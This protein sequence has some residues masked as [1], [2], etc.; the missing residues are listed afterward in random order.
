LK[1]TII[2]VITSNVFAAGI[3]FLLNILLARILSIEEFGRINLI[4]TLIIMLFSIFEFNFSNTT[5]IFYNKLKKR[6]YNDE[7][8]LLYYTNYLFLKYISYTSVLAIIIIFIIKY[9]YS[10][11]TLEISVISLNFIMF[12]LYRYIINLYQAVGEWRKFNFYN[13]LHN[14]IKSISIV[15]SILIFSIYFSFYSNYISTLIGSLIFPII[16]FIFIISKSKNLLKVKNLTSNRNKYLTIFKK[17][18]IPLGIS[19]IFIV[20]TMRADVLIIEKFLGSEALGIFAAAN[21]FALVFPLITSALRNV[22]LKESASKDKLFLKNILL[23]QRKFFPFIILIFIISISISEYLFDFIYGEK[24]KDSI[25]LFNLLLIAYIGGTFFTPLESYFYS[26]YPK[27]I[28]YL[29][30]YQMFI[31]LIFEYLLIQY[32]ELIG[33]AIAIILSRAFGW[34][35]IILKAKKELKGI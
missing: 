8:K 23:N 6:F 34:I 7:N 28:L 16:F 29:K 27:D 35:Y 11:S 22:Y 30:L 14:F 1:K 17:I 3:G 33:I 20:I 31:V 4:F 12:L 24:Y 32:Y 15:L 13:I 21:I 19:N 5:V 25:I 2:S 10:L 18:I 26:H 9:Y